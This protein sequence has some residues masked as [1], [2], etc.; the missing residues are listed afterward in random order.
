MASFGEVTGREEDRMESGR[1][2]WLRSPCG[3]LL[4]LLVA[5]ACLAGCH[6]SAQMR[7]IEI[8]LE[9]PEKDILVYDI[10]IAEPTGPRT[11]RN[12]AQEQLDALGGSPK[13]EKYP[14]VPIYEVWYRFR[15]GGETIAE[16]SFRREDGGEGA[17]VHAQTIVRALRQGPR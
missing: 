13:N 14:G 5:A 16:V 12:W 6:G 9:T 1:R 15:L 11:Y 4:G 2:A 3:L 8:E 7:P 17:L 10:E